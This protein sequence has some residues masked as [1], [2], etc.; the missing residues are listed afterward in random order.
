MGS[1]GKGATL[2]VACQE[3]L[4]HARGA[5]L[6]KG[7]PLG[8]LVRKGSGMLWAVLAKGQPFGLLVEKG[9]GSNAAKL[10]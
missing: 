8:L 5:V 9:F 4:W 7:Q 10:V 6:A 2:W 3:R 1:A